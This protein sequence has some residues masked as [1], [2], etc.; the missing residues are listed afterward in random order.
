MNP[1]EYLTNELDY[2]INDIWIIKKDN[3]RGQPYC[4]VIYHVKPGENLSVVEFEDPE[5]QPSDFYYIVNLLQPHC[6]RRQRY[7]R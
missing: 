4:K 7:R 1:H 2:P 6:C 3:D 5:V